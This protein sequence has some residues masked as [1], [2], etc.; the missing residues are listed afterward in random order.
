[1]TI[2]TVIIDNNLHKQLK[3]EALKRGLKL[4]ELVESILKKGI[5]A[6]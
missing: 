3:I 2:K 5:T 6:K 4:K 1:M